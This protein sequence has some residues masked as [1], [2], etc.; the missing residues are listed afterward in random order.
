METGKSHPVMKALFI[1]PAPSALDLSAVPATEDAS[2]GG[3]KADACQ[4]E[5]NC[6]HRFISQWL[7]KQPSAG[8]HFREQP[9]TGRAKPRP[10]TDFFS[11]NG[12]T[13]HGKVL[14]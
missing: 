12:N 6:N 4:Q 14:F 9:G 10:D 11:A 3:C 2:C 13:K 5:L 7:L 8:N 1:F